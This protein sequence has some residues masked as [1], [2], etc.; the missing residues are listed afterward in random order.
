MSE[1]PKV[2]KVYILKRVEDGGI[3]TIIRACGVMASCDTQTYAFYRKAG[4]IFAFAPI[5]GIIVEQSD[6]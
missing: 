4:Q 3:I 6:N 5:S 2:D 1:E